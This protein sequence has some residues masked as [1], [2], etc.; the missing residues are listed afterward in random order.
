MLR[1]SILHSDFVND[2]FDSMFSMPF[3][4]DKSFSDVQLK[5]NADVKEYGDKYVLELELPGFKKEE[6]KAELEEGYLTIHASHEENKDEKDE[7]GKYIR[8]ERYQGESRR[9]FYVGDSV[10]EEDIKAN[11]EN[12]VLKMTI[13]KIERK[14]EVEQTK[15][16]QIEG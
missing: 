4:F 8:K 6:I 12:G 13:P 15:Y 9:S 7:E 11:F 16:I 14:P 1:P 10:T 3:D 5:M 2:V